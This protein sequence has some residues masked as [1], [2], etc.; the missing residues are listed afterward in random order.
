L[1]NGVQISLGANLQSEMVQADVAPT[2]KA[3]YAF[4]VIDLP[5]SKTH[6]A[7]GNGGTRVRRIVTGFLPSQAVDEKFRGLP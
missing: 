1:H 3:D 7:I 5:Q 6:V 4:R 2:I